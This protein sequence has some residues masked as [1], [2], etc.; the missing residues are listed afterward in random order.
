MNDIFSSKEFL[1]NFSHEQIQEIEEKI[2][3]VES[4]DSTNTFL[5]NEADRFLP[6]LDEHGCLTSNG[7]RFNFS[8]KAAES[9]T[10]GRGRMGRTF[11]SPISS[12]IYFSISYVKKGGITDP[13]LATVSACVGVCRAIEKTFNVPCRIKWVNDIYCNHKKVCGILTEGIFNQTS[14]R[15]EGCI[16][17]IGINIRTDKSFD[18]ELKNKAGGILDGTIP[19]IETPSRTYFLANCYK[20]IK[21]ILSSDE[22]II[23]E[24]KERSILN[25]KTVTVTPVIGDDRSAYEATV[26]GISDRAELVVTLADGTTRNLSSGEVSLHGTTLS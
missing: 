26:K 15:I 19:S 11:I 2:S 4:I 12:G 10:K 7:S 6:L 16:I 17:G 9:Q 14:G 22:R 3:L 8:L 23:D 21:K 20:E 25:G 24:Y 13:A 5:M 1:S 18:C